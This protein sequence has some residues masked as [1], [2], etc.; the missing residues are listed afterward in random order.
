[1]INEVLEA[2]NNAAWRGLVS[3]IDILTIKSYGYL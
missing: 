1:M 3:N 2:I